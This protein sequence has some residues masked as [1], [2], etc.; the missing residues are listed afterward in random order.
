MVIRDLQV[1][2][3]AVGDIRT[4]LSPAAS[5]GDFPT[6]LETLRFTTP[7]RAFADQIAAAYGGEVKPWQHPNGGGKQWEVITETSDIPVGVPTQNIDPWYEVWG[8][9]EN[10]RGVGC[11]RRCDGVTEQLRDRPCLCRPDMEAGRPRLCKMMTRW[12]VGLMDLPGTGVWRCRSTGRNVAEEMGG[13]AAWIA[14]IP[15]GRRLP[16]RLFLD[17]RQSNEFDPTKNKMQVRRYGVLVVDVSQFTV[18]AF[19]NPETLNAAIEAAP[20]RPA[21]QQALPAGDGGRSELL[22]QLYRQ[23]ATATSHDVLRAVA[24]QVKAAKLDDPALVELVK[25]RWAVISTAK[26][27]PT[28]QPAAAAPSPAAAMPDPPPAAPADT[29]I[30]RSGSEPDKTAAFQNLNV[31]AGQLGWST[32]KV[33]SYVQSV[34]GKPVAACDGWD[35]ADVLTRFAKEH[36]T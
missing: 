11:L 36:T 7:M 27:P 3:A 5:G 2:N 22:V 25:T 30:A 29:P 9:I 14:M 32:S 21:G 4:G 19:A 10:Q 16:A 34:T 24:D 17:Q 1:R 26:H 31:N 20:A 12:Q 8:K 28:G 15:P 6:K 13:L 35:L 33:I 18:E 23:T